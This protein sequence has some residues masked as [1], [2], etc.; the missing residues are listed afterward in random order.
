MNSIVAI[1]KIKG[2]EL[3]TTN[4]GKRY[5]TF[6]LDIPVKIDYKG[7]EGDLTK[8]CTLW[9]FKDDVRERHCIEESWV[10]I[11]GTAE[12]YIKEFKTGGTMVNEKI[13]IREI[14]TVCEPVS[15]MEGKIG[16][17]EI[18]DEVQLPF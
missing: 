18:E 13:I 1:G 8:W 12:G 6:K 16:K 14:Q 15:S 2:V 10:C 3:K 7:T 9:L 4:S 11:S 17:E 5:I